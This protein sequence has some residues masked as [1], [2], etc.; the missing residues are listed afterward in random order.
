[1][2]A[3]IEILLQ[4]K[5]NLGKNNSK[6]EELLEEADSY[7]GNELTDREYVLHAFVQGWLWFYNRETTKIANLADQRND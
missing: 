2:S 6:V 4:A 7:Y 1:M 5:E 3:S